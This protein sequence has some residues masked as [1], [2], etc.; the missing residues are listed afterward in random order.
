[1]DLTSE[2]LTQ[3]QPDGFTRGQAAEETTEWS[4]H[5]G[6]GA[7]CME[8]ENQQVSRYALLYIIHLLFSYLY[9]R[10]H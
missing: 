2:T 1:M 7:V 8:M 4:G 10:S 9:S 6:G 5:D 3:V